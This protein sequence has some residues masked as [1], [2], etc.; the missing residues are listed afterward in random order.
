MTCRSFDTCSCPICPEQPANPHLSWFPG[1]DV[2]LKREVPA[3]VKRQRKINKR[4]GGDYTRG[5][6]TIKMLA[7]PGVITV[8]IRGLDPD[9]GETTDQAVQEWL[10]R[11]PGPSRNP[12]SVLAEGS[13]KGN[14]SVLK[15]YREQRAINKA[16][17]HE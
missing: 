17:V 13:R 2:C 14:P 15:A 3:W 10:K 4:T 12:Q 7:N 11:H 9:K 5:L 8:G 16:S 6:F 1:E